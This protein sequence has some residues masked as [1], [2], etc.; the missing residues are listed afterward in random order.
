MIG[1]SLRSD[2]L[3]ILELG[4]WAIHLADHPTWSHEDDPFREIDRER[5]LED[6]DV[7][8]SIREAEEDVKAGR[9]RGYDEFIEELR[10]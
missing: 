8:K 1:N 2:I 10:R 7:M 5:Y 3:P 9:V 6:G 4:G